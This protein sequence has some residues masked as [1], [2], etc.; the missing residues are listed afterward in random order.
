MVSAAATTIAGG[1]PPNEHLY[2][3][4]PAVMESEVAV[5]ADGG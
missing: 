3:A 4:M 2:Q 1:P 5:V